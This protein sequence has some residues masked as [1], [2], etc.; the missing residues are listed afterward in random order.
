MARACQPCRPRRCKRPPPAWWAPLRTETSTNVMGVMS[1]EYTPAQK[2]QQTPEVSSAPAGRLLLLS[3]CIQCPYRAAATLAGTVSSLR[4]RNAAYSIQ[5][6]TSQLSLSYDYPGILQHRVPFRGAKKNGA[7]LPGA[8]AP[9]SALIER[10]PL[11]G[12]LLLLGRVLSPRLAEALGRSEAD[13]AT[14]ASDTPAISATT[15]AA[16]ASQTAGFTTKVY[17]HQ[18]TQHKTRRRAGYSTLVLLFSSLSTCTKGTP[19]R[20]ARTC[21]CRVIHLSG[22]HTRVQRAGKQQ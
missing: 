5:S 4:L 3:H 19:R 8:A 7:S 15:A 12:L 21:T 11:L 13:G 6:Q 1:A 16:S 20:T 10:H 18:H 2:I 14:K 9:P 17:V 22:L